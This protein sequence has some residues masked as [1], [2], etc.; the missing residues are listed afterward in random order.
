M[1]ESQLGHRTRVGQD[2]PPLGMVQQQSDPCL[3]FAELHPG[4]VDARRFQPPQRHP[5]ECIAPQQGRKAD[6][7]AKCRQVVRQDC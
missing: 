4:E 1:M 6:T 7:R 3:R 2:A 5:A